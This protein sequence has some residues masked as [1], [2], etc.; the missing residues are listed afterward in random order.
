[1]TNRSGLSCLSICYG[2][3]PLWWLFLYFQEGGKI[4]MNILCFFAGLFIG[5]MIGVV[6]MC[7][8]QINRHYH[9]DK[10]Q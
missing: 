10:R 7:L 6:F 3:P 8:L 2:M 9:R 4:E 1:M 5:G